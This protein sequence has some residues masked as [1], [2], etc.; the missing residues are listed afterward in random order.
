LSDYILVKHKFKNSMN[1]MKTM[2][3]SDHNLLAVKICTRLNKIIR[4]Q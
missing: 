4:L 2:P 1:D 3:D